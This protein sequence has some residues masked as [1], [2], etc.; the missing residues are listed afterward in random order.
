MRANA[1]LRV[2]TCGLLFSVGCAPQS[3][4]TNLPQ[5]PLTEETSRST[6]S[7]FPAGTVA[8]APA[9]S[10]KAEPELPPLELQVERALAVSVSSV[11]LGEGGR[12]AVLG[13]VPYLGDARGLHP[14]PL[15]PALRAKPNESDDVQIFFGRDNEPRI[16]GNRHADSGETSIYWRHTSNGWKDGREELGQLGASMR[17]AL[18]GVL[19]NADPE[20][21]CRVGSLCIIKRTTGWTSAPA[22]S[23]PRRVALIEGVLW[24]L[25]QQGLANIDARGWSVVIPAPQWTK[26]RAFWALGGQAWVSTEQSLFHFQDS[27]WSELRVPVAQPAAF[28]GARPDSIWLVGKGGAARFDGHE[29]RNSTLAGP[30]SVVT[31]RGETELWFG[32]DAGLFHARL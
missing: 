2:L 8:P 31:G 24:G 3:A 16:M 21:V 15:P 11:A 26:P 27:T 4:R 17:G 18:W 7:A 12:I 28:W 30:L 1:P 13:D 14:L 20:L 22:G 5:A 19:G 29:W 23:A 10:T 32:G 9:P 25:D 6:P